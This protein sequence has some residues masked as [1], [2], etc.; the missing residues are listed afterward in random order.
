MNEHGLKLQLSAK[1]IVGSEEAVHLIEQKERLEA[2]A[3]SND[4]PLCLDL[5]KAFLETIFKTI[6]NDRLEKPQIPQQLYPLFR[7]VKDE[8]PFNDDDD[9]N[10]LVARLAGSIVN[11]V[12]ELRNQFG[13]AS[14]GNDGYHNNP[15]DMASAEFV[16]ASIDGLA[17]LMYR[18]HKHTVVAESAQR[19]NYTDFVDFN[20]WFDEQNDDIKIVVGE[21]SVFFFAASQILFE[22]DIDAYREILLQYQSNLDDD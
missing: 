19:I 5:S 7:K 18:K 22:Q 10:S 16:M 12:A 20:E 6:L 15:I 13:A 2:A 21:G 1:A 9:A 3:I 14:H 11:T 17:S 8:L 4:A